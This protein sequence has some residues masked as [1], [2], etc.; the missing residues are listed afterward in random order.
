MW[1]VITYRFS[2][3]WL[4]SKCS[5]CS[6]Q[7]NI[8]YEGQVPSTILNWFLTGDEVLGAC[9]SLIMSWPGIAVPPGSA[10]FP[11]Q[12]LKSAGRRLDGSKPS[13]LLWIQFWLF[14]METVVWVKSIHYLA[15]SP[16]K[17]VMLP[18]FLSLPSLL[19][20]LQKEIDSYSN[21]RTSENLRK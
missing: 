5:I 15:F 13:C 11:T 9:S 12:D 16:S 2:A 21:V 7:L 10:H 14:S 1:V 17:I 18:L 19:V 3:F 20:S 8:W 4:R 6:Y